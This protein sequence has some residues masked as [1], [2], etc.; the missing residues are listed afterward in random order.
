MYQ[1]IYWMLLDCYRRDCPLMAQ[2]RR[3]LMA[4]KCNVAP[5]PTED[6]KDANK[7]QYT[8]QKQA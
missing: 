7:A 6:K 4:T 8:T 5:T 2:S 1:Q 3:S